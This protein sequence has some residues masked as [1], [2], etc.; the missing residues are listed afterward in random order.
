MS[1]ITLPIRTLRTEP[2]TGTTP[3]RRLESCREY[4]VFMLGPVLSYMLDDVNI[5]IRPSRLRR[6]L[7]HPVYSSP[8]SLGTGE[9][10]AGG[11]GAGSSEVEAAAWAWPGW[12]SQDLT[13]LIAFAALGDAVVCAGVLGGR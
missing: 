11:G 7:T 4:E 1:T 3:E 13:A 2:L 10:G 8:S 9:A 12:S 5:T 6:R